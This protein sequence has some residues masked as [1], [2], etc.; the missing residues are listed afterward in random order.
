MKI[1]AKEQHNQIDR[2]KKYMTSQGYNKENIFFLTPAERESTTGKSKNILLNKE[3]INALN[4]IIKLRNNTKYTNVIL[5]YIDIINKI[6]GEV[7]M[8]N[9][10]KSAKDIIAVGKLY[11]QRQESLELILDSFMNTLKVKLKSN[12]FMN[13]DKIFEFVDSDKF[14]KGSVKG[15]YTSASKTLPIIPLKINK[16]YLKE[17]YKSYIAEEVDVYFAA[18]LDYKLYTA[19][20]LRTNGINDTI[21]PVDLSQ[22]L[23]DKLGL[24]NKS[25]SYITWDYAKYN[26]NLIDFNNYEHQTN[27]MLNLLKEGTLEIKEEYIEQICTDIIEYFKT[28]SKKYLEMD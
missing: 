20:T 11:N 8:E 24:N 26:G 14:E 27:G 19:V 3:I 10:V 6:S 5:Q 18:E 28:Y 13:N 16:K 9:Q 25:G 7:K 15:Y 4:S 22:K 2:Y 1:W 21:K 12:D 23:S 17:E